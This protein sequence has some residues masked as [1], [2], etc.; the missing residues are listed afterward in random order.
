MS[1]SGCVGD[2]ECVALVGC[3]EKFEG[4]EV[5]GTG[6]EIDAEKG[7][8]EGGENECKRKGDNWVGIVGVA[9]SREDEAEVQLVSLVCMG[10]SWE[11]ENEVQ[12]VRGVCVEWA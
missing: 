7:K 8:L 6:I 10:W 1:D 5:G 9:G 11:K 2:G 4:R 3:V 12:G